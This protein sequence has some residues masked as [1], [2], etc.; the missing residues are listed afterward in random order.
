MTDALLQNAFR[1]QQAGDFAAAA[2]L[3]RDIL[4]TTPKNHMALNLLAHLH[5]QTGRMPEAERIFAEA[6]L[7]HPAADMLYNRGCALQNLQRYEE[8]LVCF[9]RA[10]AAQ[11]DFIDAT[12]NCGVIQ[13]ALRRHESALVNFD[14]VVEKAPGDAEAWNNRANALSEL[15]RDELALAD[16]DKALALKPDYVNAWNNRGVALQRLG[17]HEEAFAAFDHALALA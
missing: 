9:Q 15:G 14:I 12:V 10:A 2:R 4:R 17:R 16:L 13:L 1:A 3:C 5:M 7:I 11:P 6:I 8:A